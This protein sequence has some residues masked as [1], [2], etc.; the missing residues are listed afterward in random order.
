[1]QVVTIE[2]NMQIINGDSI[3][4]LANLPE[5]SVDSIV[6]ISTGCDIISVCKIYK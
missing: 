3:I 5:N 1:M 2:G 4:E 6:T